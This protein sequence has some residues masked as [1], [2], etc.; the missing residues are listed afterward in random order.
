MDAQEITLNVAVNLGRL[1][2]WAHE[3]KRNRLDQFLKETQEYIGYLERSPKSERFVPTF[4]NFQRDFNRLKVDPARDERW[5]EEMLT[6]A[7]ILTH[8]AKLA[9]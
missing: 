9:N 1:A 6:W 5:A 3:G 2:R 4:V 7:N 8:R